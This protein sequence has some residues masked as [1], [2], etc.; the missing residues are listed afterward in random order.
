M[1]YYSFY[2]FFT[3]KSGDGNIGFWVVTIFT[4]FFS[5]VIGV[6]ALVLRLLKLLKLTSFMYIF[7]GILNLCMGVY[8]MTL[9]LLHRMS[10]FKYIQMH[11][12]SLLIGLMIMADLIITKK[13]SDV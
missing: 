10:E 6:I 3:D 4:L 7:S 12:Y 8:G 5:L 1:V 2:V 13:R 11:A 9:F